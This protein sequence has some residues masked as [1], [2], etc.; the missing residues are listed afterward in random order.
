MRFVN[1]FLAVIMAAVLCSC[2]L[3]AKVDSRN[4]MI[5]SKKEYKD[6]LK[7]NPDNISKCDGM[8]K[9]YEADMKA[10]RATSSGVRAGRTVDVNINNDD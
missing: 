1:M 8:K 9:A 6:C 2:G 7:Q 3:K 4:D 5:E 10:Y